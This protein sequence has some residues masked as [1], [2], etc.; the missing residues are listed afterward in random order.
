MR[1]AVVLIAL[2]LGAGCSS[3]P[4]LPQATAGATLPPTTLPSGASAAPASAVSSSGASVTIAQTQA[5]KLIFNAEAA[6]AIGTSIETSQEQAASSDETGWFSDCV[7]YRHVFFD[8]APLDVTLAAGDQYVSRFEDMKT[9]PDTSS[10]S[11]LGDDAVL[12]MSTID[13]LDGPVGALFVRLGNA[14]LGLSLGIVDVADGGG[15][16]LAG[17]A[18]RQQQILTNLAGIAIARLTGPP[19]E[20]A[21]TCRL[22]SLAD[23]A[24]LT[25]DTFASAEDVDE[26][27]ALG[28]NCQYKGDNGRIVLLLSVNSAAT[29]MSRFETCKQNGT[30]L[31]GAGDEAIQGRGDCGALVVN[32]LPLQPVVMVR[33]GETI[34][35]VAQ[36]SP[37]NNDESP[38]PG[39]AIARKVLLQLGLDPGITPAPTAYDVLAHAC[40]L[41]SQDQVGSIIGEPIT[42]TEERSGVCEFH[43][44]ADGLYTPLFLGIS[45]GADAV[46]QFPNYKNPDTVP[47][48]GVG[49]EAYSETFPGDD[50]YAATVR[51]YVLS[52]QTV[53]LLFMD[54]S[55]QAADGAYL[56][57]GTPPEQIQMLTQL[58]QLILPQLPD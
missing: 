48:A 51:I 24:A 46:S 56:A 7:Y 11:N 1:L 42:N 55:K 53:L 36:A 3:S 32:F 28:P 21:K 16:V 54:A 12:R 58:A 26:H 22:L 41:V 17:D 18:A 5:C 25:G 29:A 45:V 19:L 9:E 13:G 4:P 14:V 2:L 10:Q 39:V 38:D 30:P 33:S 35:T 47:L 6:A 8:E 27:D 50:S 40:S 20:P 49:D 34:I 31:V 23:A 43:S 52:G 37:N 57:P 15:V 44:G